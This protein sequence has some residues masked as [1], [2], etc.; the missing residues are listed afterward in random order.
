MK[1]TLLG[2][3]FFAVCFGIT[4][5][6]VGF[7]SA[8]SAPKPFEWR[9]KYATSSGPDFQPDLNPA[10]K[11]I[12]WRKKYATSPRPDFQPVFNPASKPL[13]WRWTSAANRMERLT[14]FPTP[15]PKPPAQTIMVTTPFG[16]RWNFASGQKK[17]SIPSTPTTT[18]IP[19][20][21]LPTHRFD[22]IIEDT[23][24]KLEVNTKPQNAPSTRNTKRSTL[25]G[26]R[27][28]S[29]FSQT[30][31]SIPSTT[32]TTGIPPKRMPTDR[33]ENR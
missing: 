4:Q 26:P 7:R 30:K 10:S 12:E 29:A 15:T 16:W 20:K 14:H 13:K 25:S 2:V 18:E 33:F 27:W 8:T 22:L 31:R 23:T 6:H 11:P 19:P 32:T 21:R 9:K 3:Y 24:E 1:L 28:N 5:A 17:R